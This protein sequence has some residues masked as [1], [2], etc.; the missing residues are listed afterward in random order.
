MKTVFFL[1]L[2]PL[3]AFCATHSA[4]SSPIPW[5]SGVGIEA[6]SLGVPTAVLGLSVLPNPASV[7]HAV[8]FQVQGK[9][10]ARAELKIIDVNGKLVQSLPLAGLPSG[11]MVN[12]NP[13]VKNGKP[14]ASGVYL[15]R[16]KSGKTSIEQKFMLLK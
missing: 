12:W 6:A 1:I 5:D 15:A 8:C 9:L 13:G 11:G 3:G 7:S 10:D 16:L 4:W 14:L 2:L